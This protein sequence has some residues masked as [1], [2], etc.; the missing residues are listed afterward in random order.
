MFQY[1]A[2][3]VHN[4]TGWGNGAEWARI[5]DRR[6]VRN[7]LHTRIKS[8]PAATLELVCGQLVE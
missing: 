4:E 3:Y 1:N 7:N 2:D 8:A 6:V 5:P